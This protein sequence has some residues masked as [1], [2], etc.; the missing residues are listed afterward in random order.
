ML[1][2][3]VFFMV[4]KEADIITSNSDDIQSC[5]ERSIDWTQ[6]IGHVFRVLQYIYTIITHATVVKML[7]LK[8]A[9]P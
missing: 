2:S 3:F 8:D 7:M 6:N 5:D 4:T 9:S 1:S